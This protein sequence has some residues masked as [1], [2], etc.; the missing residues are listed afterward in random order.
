MKKLY[1]EEQFLEFERIL[2]EEMFRKLLNPKEGN[3]QNLTKWIA[4]QRENGLSV[5]GFKQMEARIDRGDIA[6]SNVSKNAIS[7]IRNELKR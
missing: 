6:N 4:E 7:K 5:E 2:N 1:T 3:F